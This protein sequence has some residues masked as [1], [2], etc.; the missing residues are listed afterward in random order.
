MVKL[1]MSTKTFF[2]LKY[3]PFAPPR[4]S[5]VRA[6]NYYLPACCP[7]STYTSTHQQLGSCHLGQP[8]PRQLQGSVLY[9]QLSSVHLRSPHQ[10]FGSTPLWCRGTIS[11]CLTGH[12]PPRT[13]ACT[14]DRRLQARARPAPKSIFCLMHS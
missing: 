8:Q 5:V 14:Y 13:Y 3:L 10:S 4:P 1:P 11:L 2:L 12:S 6:R 9:P 7:T